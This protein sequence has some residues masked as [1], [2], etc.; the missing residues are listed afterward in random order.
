MNNNM[1]LEEFR[2]AFIGQ[3]KNGIGCK[4][5]FNHFMQNFGWKIPPPSALTCPPVDCE[6]CFMDLSNLPALQQTCVCQCPDL[7]KQPNLL[8]NQA[9]SQRWLC[10]LHCLRLSPVLK[11]LLE[12]ACAR[13]EAGGVPEVF[14]CRWARPPPPSQ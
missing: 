3:C 6:P 7:D 1:S 13:A 12:V 9:K 5:L 2:A 14:L 4:S 8:P 10:I 11:G